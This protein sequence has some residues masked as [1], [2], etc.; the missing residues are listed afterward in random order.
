MIRARLYILN[1]DMI[2]AQRDLDATPRSA[3]TPYA[4]LELGVLYE[5]AYLFERAVAEYSRW[6]ASYPKD[7]QVTNALN[8]RCWTRATWGQQLAEG[9]ADCNEVL[10]KSPRDAGYL[11]SRG[12]LHLRLEKYD[13]SIADYDAALKLQPKIAWSLYGRGLAKQ[14]KGL[15][16]EG[17]ADIQAALAIDPALSEEAR[18]Y[19]LR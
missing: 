13:E 11:D 16:A 6:I 10:R 19:G 9:L 1:K 14:H 2:R 18:R 3:L 5:Q 15:K 12:L 4:Q 7:P 17:D 8:A